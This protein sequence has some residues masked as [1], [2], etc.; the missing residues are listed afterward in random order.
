MVWKIDNGSAAYQNIPKSLIK[1]VQK[2]KRFP[3]NIY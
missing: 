3:L 2:V 1:R